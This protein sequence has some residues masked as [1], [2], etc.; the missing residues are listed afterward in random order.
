MAPQSERT[1][2]A[3]VEFVGDVVG[4]VVGDGGGG[5]VSF[6]IGLD[7]GEAGAGQFRHER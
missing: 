6:A 7:G 5:V 1:I 2:G 4:M 3:P